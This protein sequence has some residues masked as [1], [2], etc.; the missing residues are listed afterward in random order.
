MRLLD[1]TGKFNLFHD[2]QVKIDTNLPKYKFIQQLQ[3]KK[4]KEFGK[5]ENKVKMSYKGQE[6]RINI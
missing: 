6:L 2:E 1:S 4:E 3:K 5:G